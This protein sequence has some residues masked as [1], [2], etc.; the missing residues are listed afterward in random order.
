MYVRRWRAQPVLSPF[1]GRYDLKSEMW[2]FMT[3][4]EKLRSSGLSGAIPVTGES[5][6]SGASA[7]KHQ[8]ARGRNVR[9]QPVFC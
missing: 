7:S 1:L 6:P 5:T 8:M 3:I 9:K 4:S 2:G